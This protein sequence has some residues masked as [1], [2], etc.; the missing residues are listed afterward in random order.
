LGLSFV[1]LLD[2]IYFWDGGFRLSVMQYNGMFRYTDV[3]KADEKVL[4]AI[5]GEMK[6]QEEG[7]E[8]IASENY[9]SSAVIEALGT[10]FTNKYSEGYP[11]RRYYGGQ[12]F[13]DR[14][15]TLA[16]DR[17]KK[18]FGVIGAGGAIGGL[19][20]GVLL[21]QVI[22]RALLLRLLYTVDA[23]EHERCEAARAVNDTGFNQEGFLETHCG[24]VRVGKLGVG[25]NPVVNGAARHTD[26]E[27]PAV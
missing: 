17:A 13:T 26:G 11:G 6:R 1:F 14:I 19:V 8:M 16:I 27:T 21:R 4:A 24:F 20:A 5:V 12:E 9:A 2:L 25:L 22:G 10:V 7:L 3:K 15:E 23:L 18:L